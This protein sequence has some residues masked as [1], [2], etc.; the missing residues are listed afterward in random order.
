MVTAHV[1]PVPKP[2]E[3]G[4]EIEVLRR[5]FGDVTWEGTIHE[6]GMGPGTP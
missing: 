3:V 5:F 1:G 4:S 2:I 6:G